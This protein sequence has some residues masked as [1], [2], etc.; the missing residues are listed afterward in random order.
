M[1]KDWINQLSNFKIFARK[2]PSE[3]SGGIFSVCVPF[4]EP[5][6]KKCTPSAYR[7]F[8]LNNKIF[9]YFYYFAMFTPLF[10]RKIFPSPHLYMKL[11]HSLDFRQLLIFLY[12]HY[13]YLDKLNNQ[14]YHLISDTWHNI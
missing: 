6:S 8:L 13:K 10:F 5:G 4:L 3:I 11:L 2:I 1:S 7:T 14:D 12:R 9:F